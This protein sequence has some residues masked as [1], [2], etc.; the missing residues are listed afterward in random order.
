[1]VLSVIFEDIG[2]AVELHER[3]KK[4]KKSEVAFPSGHSI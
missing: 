3:A 4:I 1:V 2:V